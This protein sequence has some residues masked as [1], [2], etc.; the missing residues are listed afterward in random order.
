LIPVTM[1]MEMVWGADFNGY[2]VG[3]PECS[4]ISHYTTKIE[5]ERNGVETFETLNVYIDC[6]NGNV[7]EK[8]I[9]IEEEDF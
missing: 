3:F 4:V 7:V 1:K 5:V 6:T 2:E 8:W 9:T